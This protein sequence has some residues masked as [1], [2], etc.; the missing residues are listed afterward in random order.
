MGTRK[1]VIIYHLIT[2]IQEVTGL[3]ET[4]ISGTTKG[5]TLMITIF[6]A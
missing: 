4:K 5:K 3:S 6:V 2:F 1:N